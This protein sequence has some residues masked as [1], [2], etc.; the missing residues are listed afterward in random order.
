MSQVNPFYGSRYQSRRTVVVAL[1]VRFQHGG[2][3]GRLCWR[4]AAARSMVYD[5][6]I[7]R[8]VQAPRPRHY[9]SFARHRIAPPT[10]SCIVIAR[11]SSCRRRRPIGHVTGAMYYIRACVEL[12][13]SYLTD[14]LYH[15]IVHIPYYWTYT[16]LL[17]ILL[18]LLLFR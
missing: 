18:L 12:S 5:S 4:L 3:P 1:L 2:G 14:I 9:S 13:V 11:L 8:T 7:K 16:I 6:S 15:I 17:Y 10:D